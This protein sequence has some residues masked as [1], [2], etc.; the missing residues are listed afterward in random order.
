MTEL[1]EYVAA[2]EC[3]TA[4]TEIPRNQYQRVYIPLYQSHLPKLD[5]CGVIEYEKSRGL[6]RPTDRLEIF[7]PYLE[8]ITEDD[9]SARPTPDSADSD[10]GGGADWYIAA[11]GLSGLL[12]IVGALELVSLPGVALGGLIITA[13]LLANAAD[14]RY[15][16]N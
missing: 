16:T 13:F 8:S 9:S 14:T 4:T 12:L 11:A 7:R 3:E 2:A 15:S 1:V 5:E 6:V 10:E